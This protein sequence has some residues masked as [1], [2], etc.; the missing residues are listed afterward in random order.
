MQTCLFE[1]T[2]PC[3]RIVRSTLPFCAFHRYTVPSSDPAATNREF[4]LRVQRVR[5]QKNI[6]ADM[7]TVC[8]TIAKKAE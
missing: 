3:S 7:R 6:N 1:A 8:R 2:Y 4:G 5:R